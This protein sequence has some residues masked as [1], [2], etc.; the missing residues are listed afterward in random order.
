VETD[1]TCIADP[2]RAE[3]E[4]PPADEG[5]QFQHVTVVQGGLGVKLLRAAR[6]RG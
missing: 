5:D 1:V 3:F 4:L 6:P 2:R